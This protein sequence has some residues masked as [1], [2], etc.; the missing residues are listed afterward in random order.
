LSGFRDCGIWPL[1]PSKVNPKLGPHKCNAATDKN[2]DVDIADGGDNE[3][4]AEDDDEEIDEPAAVEELS[5]TGNQIEDADNDF[6]TRAPCTQYYV[7]ISEEEQSEIQ[8]ERVVPPDSE[9]T[10]IEDSEEAEQNVS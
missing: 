7:N 8:V 9:L 1:N 4:M 5:V 3:E 2:N 10:A 6:S